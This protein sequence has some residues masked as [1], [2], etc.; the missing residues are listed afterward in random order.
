MK[1][2]LEDAKSALAEL[3]EAQGLGGRHDVM[4]QQLTAKATIM[5][6]L[7]IATYLSYVTD[8]IDALADKLPMQ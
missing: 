7:A 1:N 3:I 2:P 4:E 6:L 5:A 8:S